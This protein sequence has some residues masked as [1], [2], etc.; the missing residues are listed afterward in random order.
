MC[1][2]ELVCDMILLQ[3]ECRTW[4]GLGPVRHADR[5][6]SQA[7]DSNRTEARGPNRMRHFVQHNTCSTQPDATSSATQLLQHGLYGHKLHRLPGA[8]KSVN[9]AECVP[10]QARHKRTCRGRRTLGCSCTQ[11]I[12]LRRQRRS[13]QSLTQLRSQS[14]SYR[15]R[16]HEGYAVLSVE[17]QRGSSSGQGAVT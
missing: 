9:S 8:I 3:P 12:I 4:L 13:L 5:R 11:R 7:A 15:E 1:E 17:W 16:T 6:P 2:P 14:R 10:R